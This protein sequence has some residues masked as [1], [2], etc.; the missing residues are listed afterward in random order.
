MPS[1]PAQAKASKLMLHCKSCKNTKFTSVGAGFG[2]SY[3]PRVC[4][5]QPPGSIEANCGV[6]PYVILPGASR[7][8]ALPAP[9]AVCCPAGAGLTRRR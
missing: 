4:D 3:I 1:L 5:L 8:A 6:D 7:A 9:L 2:G